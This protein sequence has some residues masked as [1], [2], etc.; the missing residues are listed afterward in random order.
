MAYTL[1]LEELDRF[2]YGHPKMKVKI[3]FFWLNEIDIFDT[4]GVQDLFGISLAGTGE[5][6]HYYLI[7]GIEVDFEG[8]ALILDLEDVNYLIGSGSGAGSGI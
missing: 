6:V 8:Y 2:A 4:I 1:A 7:D 5:A 3:P